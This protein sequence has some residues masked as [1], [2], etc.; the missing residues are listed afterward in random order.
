LRAVEHDSGSDVEQHTPFFCNFV[1]II[2]IIITEENDPI[3]LWECLE[4]LGKCK[5]LR[6]VEVDLLHVVL[7]LAFESADKGLEV[8]EQHLL[9][10]LHGWTRDAEWFTSP[11]AAIQA[12]PGKTRMPRIGERSQL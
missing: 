6:C 7:E 3:I 9:E 8:G 12:L 11:Y 2:I 10:L 4:C 1:I 5:D